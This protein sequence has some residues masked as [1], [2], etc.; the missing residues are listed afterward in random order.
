MITPMPN[1]RACTPT[2][3]KASSRLNSRHSTTRLQLTARVAAVTKCGLFA[4]L[5]Q[6]V[7]PSFGNINCHCTPSSITLGLKALQ[8]TG[9]LT[10][11]R[12][13]TLRAM[14]S[15]SASIGWR[16]YTWFRSPHT[17][18]SFSTHAAG[19][20]KLPAVL[21]KGHNCSMHWLLCD[22]TRLA[23]AWF[24]AICSIAMQTTGLQI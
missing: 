16:F 1:W 4:G 11:L 3:Y 17:L 21:P 15:P 14:P 5:L 13:D 19:C 18:L 2:T 7:R 20:Q 12:Y 6:I 10:D 22:E 8:M 9:R 24:R 23:G